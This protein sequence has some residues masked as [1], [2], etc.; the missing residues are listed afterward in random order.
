MLHHALIPE[1]CSIQTLATNCT[2]QSFD[3]WG[4]LHADGAGLNRELD[5]E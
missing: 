4:P 5:Y 2:Y 1:W 3:K